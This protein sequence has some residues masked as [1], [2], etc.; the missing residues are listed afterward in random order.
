MT[1]INLLP[2]REDLRHAARKEFLI[3]FA[4]VFILSVSIWTLGVNVIKAKVQRLQKV[5]ATLQNDLDL[6]EPKMAAIALA[7]T[8][9]DHLVAKRDALE[10]LQ[11]ERRVTVRLL[12]QVVY[13]IPSG[14]YLTRFDRKGMQLT[15][16]GVAESNVRVSEF[17][18]KIGRSKWITEPHLAEIKAADGKEER[19]SY[20]FKITARISSL[21]ADDR[22]EAIQENIG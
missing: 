17:M 10:K 11:L 8:E 16:E 14:V 4:V 20:Y 2:W 21:R 13:Q 6:L 19:R 1:T 7:Q 18:Q 12:E 22:S 5:N 9:L 3:L 15:F